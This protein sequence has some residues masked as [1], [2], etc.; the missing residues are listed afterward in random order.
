MDRRSQKN[1]CSVSVM[2]VDPE[3]VEQTLSTVYP[4]RC[5]KMVSYNKVQHHVIT[6]PE[7]PILD[8]VFFSSF[9]IYQLLTEKVWGAGSTYF[10]SEV[11]LY[12]CFNFIKSAHKTTGPAAFIKQLKGGM[13]YSSVIILMMGGKAWH[14][15]LIS[16][17]RLT[18][19]LFRQVLYFL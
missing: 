2:L 7:L 3:L 8:P 17:V 19:T 6:L 10:K 12:P 16:S 9:S 14:I 1:V 4:G 11:E 5:C 18:I 15:W 13:P